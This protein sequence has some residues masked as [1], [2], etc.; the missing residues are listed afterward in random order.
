MASRSRD[1]PDPNPGDTV[2]YLH[3]VA[4]TG[5]GSDT[6]DLTA[7]SSQGW[8]VPLYVDDGDGVFEPGIV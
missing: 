7:S 6:I 2:P 3:T 4:N 1:S 8:T 5:N